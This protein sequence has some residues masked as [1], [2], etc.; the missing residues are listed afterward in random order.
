M[1][2]SRVGG[3][4]GQF[5]RVAIGKQLVIDGVEWLGL[6]R[7]CRLRSPSEFDAAFGAGE[8]HTSRHFSAHVLEN[9]LATPR[10]GLA[11]AKRRIRLASRRNRIKRIIRE[12]FRSNRASLPP[13]DIVIV[14]RS[15]ADRA[16]NRQLRSTI[17]GLWEAIAR[18]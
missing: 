15:S 11:V 7:S 6:P 18:R 8:R 10:I 1:T 17:D 9:G 5:D 12:S 4:S 3:A 2:G 13:V 14:V 16:S